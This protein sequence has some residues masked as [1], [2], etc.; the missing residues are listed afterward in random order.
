MQPLSVSGTVVRGPALTRLRRL[1]FGHLLPAILFSGFWVAKLLLSLD[2]LRAPHNDAMSVIYL[3]N[4][5]LGLIFYTITIVLFSVRLP[6]LDGDRRAGIVFAS[7]FGTLAILAI[8][9]LP[10][11]GGHPALILPGALLLAA[12][13]L[14]SIWGLATLRRSFSILP[15]ARRLVVRGP[16]AL[17]RNPLYLGE[18]VAAVGLMLPSVGVWQVSLLAAVVAAQLVRIHAEEGVLEARFG[19]EYRDYRAAVPRYLPRLWRG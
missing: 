15:E 11:R 19:S 2:A 18:F 17:S 3:V 4:L 14:Y 10:G 1:F 9:V 5:V 16:Y 7:F 6:R 13:I 8:G 12:G